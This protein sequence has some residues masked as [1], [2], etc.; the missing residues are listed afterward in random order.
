M[1]LGFFRDVLDGLPSHPLVA[2][3]LTSVRAK[4]AS[5]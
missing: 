2:A 5:P 3:A 1:V 4:V